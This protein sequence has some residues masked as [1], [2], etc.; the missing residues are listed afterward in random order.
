MHLRVMYHSMAFPE[1]RIKA[2]STEGFMYIFP[3]VNKPE[4]LS[5]SFSDVNLGDYIMLTVLPNLTSNIT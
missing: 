4:V 2:G 1:A 3:Y 5:K